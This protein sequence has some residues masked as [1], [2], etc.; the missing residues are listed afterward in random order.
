[1]TGTGHRELDVADFDRD[2]DGDVATS[3]VG[4][5][6][7]TSVLLNDGS[8]GLAPP[9]TYPGEIIPGYANQMALDTGDVNGDGNLDIVVANRTGK[10][11]GV[12]FGRGDGTF[13]GEQMRYGMHA[14]LTDVELADMNGDGRLDAVGPTNPTTTTAT[15]AAATTAARAAAASPAPGVSVLLNGSAAGGA[16][17]LTVEKTG[18]GRGRVTSTPAGLDCGTTCSSSYAAGT[19]VTLTAT[20]GIN[21]TFTGWSGACTGTAATCTVLMTEAR[22]VTATFT[23]R[24]YTLTVTKTGSGRGRVSSIPAGINCGTTCSSSYEAGTLVTL[25]ATP[26]INSIFTGWSGA[27]T[28]TGTTCRVLMTASKSVNAR[29]TRR[30]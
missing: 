25:V 4:T 9:T 8:G 24:M 20:P 5:M 19:L 14:D 23:A 11:I 1:V 12:Y 16:F 10:D 21:S 30:Q 3:N 7:S 2:G 27:C 15:T 17:T 22:S 29:F 28:G 26:A 13:D 18:G 6:D